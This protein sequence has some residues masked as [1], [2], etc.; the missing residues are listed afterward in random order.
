METLSIFEAPISGALGLYRYFLLTGILAAS[1]VL[2]NHFKK[3][4]RPLNLTIMYSCCLF[5]GFYFVAI[6]QEKFYK[7]ILQNNSI[8]LVYPS[9]EIYLDINDIEKSQFRFKN[10]RN[11][12]EVTCRIVLRLLHTTIGTKVAKKMV[13][14]SRRPRT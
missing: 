3:K 7:A 10:Y 11:S 8:V 1:V 5:I 6:S 14:V 13:V 12:T 2:Y 9:K 4:I